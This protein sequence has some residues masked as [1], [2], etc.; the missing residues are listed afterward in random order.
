M[1][2]VKPLSGL[3]QDANGPVQII[4]SGNERT[5]TE[6]EASDMNVVLLM[7]IYDLLGAIL[8]QLDTIVNKL[9]DDEN[10]NFDLSESV[11]SIHEQG[12]LVNDLPTLDLR[13]QT[14]E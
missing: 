1:E 13:P 3:L 12:G 4:E 9:S 8:E 5:F 7:R 6:A 2:E 10:E 14:E 11:L